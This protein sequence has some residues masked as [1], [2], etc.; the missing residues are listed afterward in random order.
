MEVVTIGLEK[1]MSI[2]NTEREDAFA[3]GY[4]KA[5]KELELVKTEPKFNEVLRG[6]KELKRYLEH[7]GYWFR[8]VN[9]LN[10]VAIQLLPDGE[11]QGHGLEFRC[12]CIDHAFANGFR[13]KKPVKKSLAPENDN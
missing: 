11:K 12:T 1:L 8:S 5:K 2:I 4:I 7:K 6:V 13:F 10:K 3:N 9:T